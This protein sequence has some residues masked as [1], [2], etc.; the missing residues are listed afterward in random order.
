MEEKITIIEG[1]PPVFEAVDDGWALSLNE[2]SNLVNIVLT[3]VRTFNGP[4]LV[5]RCHRA[6]RNGNNINLEFRD[7]NGLEAS[8]P[9]LAA[10]TLESKDGQLLLM[11]VRIDVNEAELEADYDDD[12]GDDS[13]SDFGFPDY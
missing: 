8:V 7:E 10:R 11:W 5:E 12:L 3:R 4:A 6:W 9:I 1:P 2:S 13:D